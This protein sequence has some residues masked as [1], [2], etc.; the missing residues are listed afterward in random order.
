M[1]E[2]QNNTVKTIKW[3]NMVVRGIRS[4]KRNVTLCKQEVPCRS[5]ALPTAS[6][7]TKLLGKESASSVEGLTGKCVSRK[8][9]L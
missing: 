3:G 6:T 2:G 7:C 8:E 1:S 5:S 9:G 4:E